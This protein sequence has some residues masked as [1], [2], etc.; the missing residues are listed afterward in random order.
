MKTNYFKEKLSSQYGAGIHLVQQFSFSGIN[1][2]YCNSHNN[3]QV[4]DIHR[5][6]LIRSKK[7]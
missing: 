4:Q 5:S 6:T 7:T 2:S 3:I 1:F